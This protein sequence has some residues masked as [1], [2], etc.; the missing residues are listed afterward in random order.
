MNINQHMTNGGCGIYL[1]Y[2]ESNPDYGMAALSPS[3]FASTHYGGNLVITNSAFRFSLAQGSILHS[4]AGNLEITALGIKQN[5][6]TVTFDLVNGLTVDTVGTANN[7]LVTVASG[8]TIFGVLGRTNTWTGA[9]N[10][11]TSMVYMNQSNL[12]NHAFVTNLYLPG[13]VKTTATFSTNVYMLGPSNTVSSNLYVYGNIDHQ[14][15]LWSSNAVITNLSTVNQDTSRNGLG[16]Y[17][18]SVAMPNNVDTYAVSATFP[19]TPAVVIVTIRK[20]TAGAKTLVAS[21][22]GD[23]I[24]ASGFTIEMNGKTDTTTYQVDWIAIMP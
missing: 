13:Q 12:V 5:G 19:T 6:V 16:V 20:P 3:L 21:V 4:G 18:G 14:N 7:S 1:S 2:N 17:R 22:V 24:S 8:G 11:F 15:T 9:S 10:T 23:T